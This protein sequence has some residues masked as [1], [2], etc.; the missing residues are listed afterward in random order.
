[1]L[2]NSVFSVVVD[3]FDLAIIKTA[4][5]R[6]D[7]PHKFVCHDASRAPVIVEVGYGWPSLE[8]S[9]QRMDFR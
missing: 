6:L 4:V 1:M 3:F 7:S 8:K 9:I 2:C 5:C